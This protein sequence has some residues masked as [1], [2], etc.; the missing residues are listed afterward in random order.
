MIEL[1]ILATLLVLGYGFGRMAEQRHYRSIRERE[2]R[3]RQ[4]LVFAA[5]VPPEPERPRAS[6]LVLGS[7]VISVDFFKQFVASLRSLLGGR[8]TTYEGLLERARREAILRL[9]EDAA[10][11][12]ARMVFNIRFE[13]AAISAGGRNGIGSVEVLAYGTAIAD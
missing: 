4:V 5:R 3:Y 1:G 9:K 12:G 2:A 10:R 11:H 8:L 13:T 7:V 6:R